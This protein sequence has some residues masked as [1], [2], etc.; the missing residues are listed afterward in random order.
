LLSG[1]FINLFLDDLELTIDCVVANARIS[2]T[3]G[4]RDH[5][6][7]PAYA[8]GG[9]VG[10]LEGGDVVGAIT[11]DYRELGP[12]RCTFTPTTIYYTDDTSVE[13]EAYYECTNDDEG[14]ATIYMTARDA[15][16]ACNEED[17]NARKNRGSIAVN[18]ND[19]GD[20]ELDISGGAGATGG[21]SCLATGNVIIAGPPPVE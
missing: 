9:A 19:D 3:T 8:F 5:R 12:T 13:I 15:H 1:D 4:V 14:T 2:G 17:K 11:I 6:K 20:A 16:A 18:S 21:E 7:D 10:T